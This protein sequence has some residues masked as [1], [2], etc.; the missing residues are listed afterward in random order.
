MIGRT[1]V[2]GMGVL[3]YSLTWLMLPLFE[4]MTLAL[5][6]R[7]SPDLQGY[8]VISSVGAA[9]LF[10]LLFNSGEILD[11]ERGR[12]TLG[13][14]FLVPTPRFVW[15]AGFQLFALIE[16]VANATV[17]ITAGTLIFDV[18]LD[19]NVVTLAATLVLFSLA[20]WGMSL[21]L[22][23]VGL[24]VRSA[25]ALSNILYPVLLP[26]SGVMYPLDRIPDW[27]RIPARCLPFGYGIDAFN[28]ALSRG[29]SL[30]EVGGSLLR[31]ALFAVVLPVIGVWLFHST[32]RAVRKIGSLEII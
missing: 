14:L 27:L 32:D 28:A 7:N 21:I 13:N 4:M 6:Y 18:P 1:R 26:L 25:N 3:G 8:A 12:G 19:V 11:A 23:S 2:Q 16:A 5:I 29:A 17:A 24:M 10:A 15:L 9:V 31:L 22:G 20:L 30:D